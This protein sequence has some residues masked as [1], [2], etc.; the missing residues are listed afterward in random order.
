M[1]ANRKL[2][3]RKNNKGQV[4]IGTLI[5]FIAMV[6]VAAV[7]ASVLIQTSG[8]LQQRAQ[9][10]GSEATQEV[11]SNIDIKSIEGVRASHTDDG[12]SDTVDLLRLQLGLQ[13]GS[14]P[15]DLNQLVV[16]ITDGSVT[17]TLTYIDEEH[18]KDDDSWTD[19]LERIMTD[20]D[21]ATTE[22]AANDIRDEDESFNQENPVMNTGDLVN[23]YIASASEE[24]SGEGYSIE[25]DGADSSDG[26][27]TNTGLTIDPRTEVG[28]VMTPEAGAISQATFVTPSTYGVTDIVKLYP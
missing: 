3:F 22:F 8:V 13:A 17:N 6:L 14:S 19:N 20:D 7:A 10:T 23:L 11:S 1:K 12:L 27:L 25:I 21:A 9:Q 16:T 4:G 15:V 5:I 18:V 24:G 28:I 2:N 26:T